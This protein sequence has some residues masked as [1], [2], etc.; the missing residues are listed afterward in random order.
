MIQDKLRRAQE[1][2]LSR[3][4]NPDRVTAVMHDIRLIELK[5]KKLT[6]ISNRSLK[7]VVESF[8]G[9]LKLNSPLTLQWIDIA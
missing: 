4:L 8:Q 5:F 3:R 2:L 6:P 9:Y 1:R 7:R